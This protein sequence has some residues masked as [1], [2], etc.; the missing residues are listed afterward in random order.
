MTPVVFL[1]ALFILF[2]VLNFVRANASPDEPLRREVPGTVRSNSPFLPH[3]FMFLADFKDLMTRHWNGVR[4]YLAERGMQF[5]PV[6]KLDY[7]SN[8]SGGKQYNNVGV[9]N[10]DLKISGTT[11]K[12]IGLD[13][14]TFLF[15]GLLNHGNKPTEFIGDNQ[16]TTNI[17]TPD[18]G[19]NAKIYELWV[20][21]AFGNDKGSFLFGLH[22][23]NSEFY[24][25][26]SSAPLLNASF[27]VGRELSQTGQYGPSIFPVTS[28]CFRLRYDF[29]ILE[30]L[31]GA[32]DGVSGD[33]QNP[34]GTHIRFDSQDGL[35]W[36]LE[37]ANKVDGQSK[38]GIGT[39]RY[40][41]DFDHLSEVDGSGNPLKHN[42]HGAYLLVEKRVQENAVAFLRY[43]EASTATNRFKSNL[44]IGLT[45]L[46]ISFGMTQATL[47]NEY[48]IANST[49]VDNETTWEANYEHSWAPGLIIKPDL[50]HIQNP[51]NLNVDNV[52]VGT[53]RLQAEL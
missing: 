11:D 10:F 29:E 37:V 25:T 44:A 46:N 53:L 13:G 7:V 30:M 50:Q 52:L 1:R 5:L 8:F 26:E 4:S 28:T 31:V 15:Y 12:L 36:I 18:G 49:S 22:D 20:Q 32:F 35:L 34:K 43:G 41:R 9:G 2:A 14:F 21:R 51:D 6:Y 23:L 48:K 3:E 17:E 40:T 47:G 16:T 42:S 27:G 38:I 39:W 19:F 45:Y 33:P 24:S